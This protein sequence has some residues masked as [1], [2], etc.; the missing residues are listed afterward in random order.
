MGILTKEIQESITYVKYLQ[1]LNS[2]EINKLVPKGKSNYRKQKKTKMY[3]ITISDYNSLLAKVT[4]NKNKTFG[5]GFQCLLANL[6]QEGDPT[7]Y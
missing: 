3:C 2:D 7:I 6:I 5:K 1:S 4:T